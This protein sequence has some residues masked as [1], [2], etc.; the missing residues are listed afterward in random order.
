MLELLNNLNL[1]NLTATNRVAKQQPYEQE[2]N[3]LFGSEAEVQSG[4]GI[5]NVQVPT[6][7]QTE[8]VSG[9]TSGGQTQEISIGDLKKIV[10]SSAEELEGLEAEK[11]VV[12]KA[13]KAFAKIKDLESLYAKKLDLI[14]KINKNKLTQ[15]QINAAYDNRLA[16]LEKNVDIASLKPND[17]LQDVTNFTNQDSPVQVAK[18]NKNSVILKYGDVTQEV[19]EEELVNNFVKPTNNPTM[20][21][22]EKPSQETVDASEQTKTD[23]SENLRKKEFLDR[24]EKEADDSSEDDLFKNL[25]DNS[26]TC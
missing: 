14:A 18:V 13:T 20:E 19:T 6:G 11:T 22:V 1:I 7:E 12:D 25:E 9:Q 26:K 8:G 16:E 10:T 4:T 5:P 2:L 24:S 3:K 15:S 21:E 17:I 23:A